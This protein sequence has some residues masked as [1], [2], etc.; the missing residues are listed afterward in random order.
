M[1]VRRIMHM[2]AAAE[3]AANGLTVLYGP[4]EVHEVGDLPDDI[5]IRE[6]I[7]S[8]WEIALAP[9]AAQMSGERIMHQV[10]DATYGPD[11][12]TVL[13]G[14]GELHESGGLPEGVGFRAVV[15][16]DVDRE[17]APAWAQPAPPAPPPP[18]AAKAETPAPAVAVTA[19]PK[20]TA[21]K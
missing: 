12:L 14:P 9:K 19:P 18:A 11:G 15:A 4:G 6:V 5:P 8:D 21:K 2:V 3:Y 20:A 1:G 10:V 13:F 17:I 16:D 7:M